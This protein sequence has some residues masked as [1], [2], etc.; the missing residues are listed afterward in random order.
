MFVKIRPGDDF[1]KSLKYWCKQCQK[2]GIFDE[3]KKR[4]EYVGKSLKRR[5]K[6]K[7]ARRR[8]YKKVKKKLY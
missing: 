3:L 2:E 8:L 4:Q 1:E 7:N 5:L 6:S